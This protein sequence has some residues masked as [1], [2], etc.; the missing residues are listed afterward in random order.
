MS[1]WAVEDCRSVKLQQRSGESGGTA[2]TR[3]Q[4]HVPT[5]GTMERL[6][7]EAR[8]SPVVVMGGAARRS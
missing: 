7:S 1:K 2:S 5:R 3:Q 8:R 4:G 6:R